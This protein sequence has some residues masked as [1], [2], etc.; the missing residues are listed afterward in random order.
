MDFIFPLLIVFG[1]VAVGGYGFYKHAVKHTDG[2]DDIRTADSGQKGLMS[3]AHVTN[4]TQAITDLTGAITDLDGFPDELKNLTP[5]EIAIVGA[6]TTHPIGGDGTAGRILRGTRLA[7]SNGGLA[8]TLECSMSSEWNGDIIAS[9]DNIA[10]GATTGDFSLSAG[11]TTLT[12]EASGLS[13]NVVYV[14]GV[15][16]RNYSTTNLTTYV[17]VGTNDI[18]LSIY[19]STTGTTLD[20]TTLVDTGSIYMLIFYITSA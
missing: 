3:S 2:T 17:R 8:A 7:I 16:Y 5:E 19:N 15:V 18:V 14:F 6:L 11:G 10:K 4:L 1:I 12:V 13:G 9:T 20:I